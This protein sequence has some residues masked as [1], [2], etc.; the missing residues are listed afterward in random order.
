MSYDSSGELL[1]GNIM[2][3]CTASET[4]L[5]LGV[6]IRVPFPLRLGQAQWENQS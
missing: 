5:A 1:G 6:A 2:N 3:A 4:Y